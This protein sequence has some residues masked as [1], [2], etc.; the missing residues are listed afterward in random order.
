[1]AFGFTLPRRVAGPLDSSMSAG[2]SAPQAKPM[3][4]PSQG[5]QFQR[6]GLFGR[7]RK[8]WPQMLNIAGAAMR[9]IDDDSTPA[10][11]NL[12][13]E[14]ERQRLQN[15]LLGD[16]KEDRAWQRYQRGHELAQDEATAERQRVIMGIIQ[17]LPPGERELAS[18]DPEGYVA[19][20]MRHRYPAPSRSTAAGA[21]EVPD[22]LEPF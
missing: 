6:G 9:Q 4:G 18:L 20:M 8:A 12:M 19:G 17:N 13:A 10:L 11:D 21:R 7:M 22:D 16:R 5:V 1:M 14:Q 3:G 2:G 15:M